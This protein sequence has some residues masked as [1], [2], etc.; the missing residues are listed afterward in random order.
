MRDTIIFQLLILIVVR[1]YLLCLI[2]FHYFQVFI[3]VLLVL[4]YVLF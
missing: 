4:S 1:V 3:I 2:S